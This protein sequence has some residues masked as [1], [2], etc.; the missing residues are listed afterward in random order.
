MQVSL[1]CLTISGAF[2]QHRGLALGIGLVGV[3]IG[4]AIVPTITQGLLDQFGWRGAF[5]GLGLLVLAIAFPAV[6][7]FLR[8]PVKTGNDGNSKEIAGMAASEVTRSREFRLLVIVFLC[9][10]LAVNGTIVHLMPLLTDRGV[11]TTTAVA[12]FS[13]VG[14]SLII[15]RLLC[16]YLMDRFFAPNVAILF[17]ALPALGVLTLAAASSV[18]L[19]IL[20]AVLVGVGLGAEIDIIA[21]L[22][23]RYF[24]LRAFGQVYGYLFMA[25]AIG[26]SL[27]PLAMGL[28]FD[29]FG[30]YRTALSAFFG[31]A[32]GH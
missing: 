14:A 26:G 8:E 17:V 19:N 7:L 31:A 21:Y 2:D 32:G 12:V 1:L 18:P 5:V 9:V 25:F 16:G 15:G 22:Q 13:G 11:A 6:A 23:S 3:G 27:G 29:H 4:T 20:G 24:G 10:P 28:S 30:S